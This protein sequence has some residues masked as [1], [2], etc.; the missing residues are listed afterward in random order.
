MHETKVLLP[1]HLGGL[2]LSITPTVFLSFLAA[3]L[4]IVFLLLSVR[5]LDFVPRRFGQNLL[6]SLV[7]FIEKQ[8]VSQAE[9][10][11]KTWTPLFLTVFLFILFSSLPLGLL[12]ILGPR[13]E[14]S[15]AAANINGTAALAVMIFL[16]GLFVRFKQHGFWGFFKSIV[17]SG[18]NGPISLL[19]FPIELISQLFKPFSLAIR[20]FANMSAGHVLLLSILGFTALFNNAAVWVLSYGGAL[21]IVFFEIFV[22]F[23]QAYVFTLLS[24]LLIGESV[25]E[26]AK[27]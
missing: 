27:I 23:I 14:L 5:R 2:D 13:A 10:D 15:T 6:E 8:I 11:V 17:P 25:G 3:L 20:L 24:A 26:E 7:E 9:L 1:L 19:L 4:L 12:A 21:V 16:I 22:C 18:V